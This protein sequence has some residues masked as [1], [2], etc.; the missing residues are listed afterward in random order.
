M[1]A[2][3]GVLHHLGG[4]D[5]GADHRARRFRI[6]RGEQIAARLVDLADHGLRRM[7]VVVHR[8][9]FAQEL[10]VD[11][12]AELL[13]GALAGVFF[14]QGNDHAAHGPGEHGAAKD[15]HRRAGMA[16]ERP[17]DLLADALHVFQVDAAVRLARRADADERQ[18][19]VAHRVLDVGRGVQASRL[20][21]LGDDLAQVLLD[22]R[23]APFVDEVDLGSLR[24]DA[25]DFVAF[26]CQEPCGY[27][28][29]VS[30][31]Q[32]ADF[33]RGEGCANFVERRAEARPV[34]VVRPG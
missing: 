4:L 13:A 7:V 31:P 20:H 1:P 16:G 17:A 8:G 26:S 27:R 19:G 32:H 33:H 9:A 23:R 24:I 11:A 2:V 22:D 18:I 12:D 14:Q 34:L 10:G 29:D 6:Q 25:D 21:L 3:V 5:V 15:N 30:E 28:P